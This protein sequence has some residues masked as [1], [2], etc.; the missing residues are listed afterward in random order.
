MLPKADMGKF[1]INWPTWRYCT[2][3]SFV[4][5]KLAYSEKYGFRKIIIVNPIVV[6][7]AKEVHLEIQQHIHKYIA[8]LCLQQRTKRI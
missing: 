3:G 1:C 7:Q 5:A 6:L 8:T 2:L 4:I